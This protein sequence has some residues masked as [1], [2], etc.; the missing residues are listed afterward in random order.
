MAAVIPAETSQSFRLAAMASEIGDLDIKGLSVRLAD[1]QEAILDL[2]QGTGAASRPAS[3]LRAGVA[4][5][6]TG[7]DLRASK[8][9]SGVVS[10]KVAAK[11]GTATV[12]PCRVIE[13][14]PLLRIRSS[15]LSHGSIIAHDGER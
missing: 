12:V 7:S 8:R 10:T 4:S 13:A 5:K 15:N 14:Q 3:M 2:P 1:G 9:R 11:S 6:F